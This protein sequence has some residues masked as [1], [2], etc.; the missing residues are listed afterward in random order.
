MLVYYSCIVVAP[1]LGG[2]VA[3]IHLHGTDDSIVGTANI[4]L[5]GVSLLLLI[6]P[7]LGDGI[8]VH[9]IST[10]FDWPRAPQQTRSFEA[11]VED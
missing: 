9:L 8:S 6:P 2:I 5:P 1:A 10:C 3:A 11:W 7:V 4:N